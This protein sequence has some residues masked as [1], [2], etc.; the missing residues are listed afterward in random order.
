MALLAATVAAACFGGG[1]LAASQSRH[2]AINVV[3][4][5]PLHGEQNSF[6]SLRVGSADTDGN[7][8]IEMKVSGLKDLHGSGDYYILM[9]VRNG[10]PRSPCGYFRVRNGAANLRFNVPYKITG[11]TQ[12]VVTEMDPGASFPGHVVMS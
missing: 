12:W 5:V 11:T 9:L 10:K 4:V 1:Y 7:W 3:R 6:A 8:P 2:D